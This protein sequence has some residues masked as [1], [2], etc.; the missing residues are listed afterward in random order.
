MR[1]VIF[2]KLSPAFGKTSFASDGVEAA[3]SNAERKELLLRGIHSGI[4]LFRQASWQA[5]AKKPF[6]L[7]VSALIAGLV[8]IAMNLAGVQDTVSLSL[9]P[10]ILLVVLYTYSNLRQTVILVGD[11]NVDEVYSHNGHRS[12]VRIVFIDKDDDQVLFSIVSSRRWD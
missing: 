11:M 12:N 7:M 5:K 4:V 2:E 10:A 1:S 8:L 9:S 3:L 6:T